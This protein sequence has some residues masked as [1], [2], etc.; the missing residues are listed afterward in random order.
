MAEDDPQGD[1]SETCLR[2]VWPDFGHSTAGGM[3][4]SLPK[5]FAKPSTGVTEDV[6]VCH[7]TVSL[8]VNLKDPPQ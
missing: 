2:W 3:T 7:N 4:K 6:S 5:Q 1:F 8:G